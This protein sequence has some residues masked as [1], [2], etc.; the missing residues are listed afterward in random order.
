MFAKIWEGSASRGPLAIDFFFFTIYLVPEESGNRNCQN[1]KS[2]ISSADPS[3]R[4]AEVPWP[5][6][7]LPYLWEFDRTLLLLGS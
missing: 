7:V 6:A 2:V 3:V 1:R 4:R 5:S